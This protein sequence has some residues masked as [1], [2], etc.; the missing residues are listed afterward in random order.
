MILDKQ[1]LFIIGSPRSGT[2][3]LQ[4]M[5]NAHP[6]VCTTVELTLFDKYIASWIEFWKKEAAN[7]DQGRWHKGLPFL[8]TED[9]FYGFLR[10]FLVKVYERVVAT[11]PQATHIL[12]KNPAYALHVETIN[13]FLSD[14]RFIHVIRDGRDAAVSLLAARRQ[15][16]FGPDSIQG[17]AETWKNYV[18]AAQKTTKYNDRYMEVRYE[19]L[20]DDGIGILKSVFDFCGLSASI[21]DVAAIVNEHAFEKMKASRITPAKNVKGPE[22]GYRKGKAGSWR[23]E[24]DPMQRY[25]FDKI[26]GELLRELGYA[27]EGWWA[28]SKSQRFVLPIRATILSRKPAL[29]SATAALLGP[30]LTEHI[31]AVRSKRKHRKKI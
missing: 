29:K 18:R 24:L 22:G 28:E 9:E 10:E 1:F 6:L 30:T 13:T 16:G 20:L 7:I 2:T 12:D 11:N 4:L 8:W 15:I 23:E 14:A 5:I 25:V 26:A 19:E 17:A 21:E 3:W 31:K 27:E